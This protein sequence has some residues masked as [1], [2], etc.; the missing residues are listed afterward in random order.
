MG[1]SA[2]TVSP[3]AQ[4]PALERR[5]WLFGFAD[6]WCRGATRRGGLLAPAVR[7]RETGS[8]SPWLDCLDAGRGEDL[9]RFLG[10]R[11]LRHFWGPLK[12]V[13]KCLLSTSR[14][15]RA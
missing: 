6:A 7:R 1:R 14:H 10:S 11:L 2:R 12:G 4:G 3:G 8:A 9:D 15:K 5:S 13:A